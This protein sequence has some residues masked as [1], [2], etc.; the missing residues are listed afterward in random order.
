MFCQS[1]LA[2]ISVVGVNL[3]ARPLQTA[4]LFTVRGHPSEDHAQ[5]LRSE[6]CDELVTTTSR[7]T[8][9]RTRYLFQVYTNSF[10]SSNLFSII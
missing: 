3:A 6:H 4:I 9:R 5:Q 10:F 1:G 7:G 8:L 2:E